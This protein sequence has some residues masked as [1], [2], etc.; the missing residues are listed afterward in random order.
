MSDLLWVIELAGAMLVWVRTR[1]SSRRQQQAGWLMAAG[2]VL[3]AL[4]DALEV[5]R[6]RS[7]F[8][9]LFESWQAFDSSALSLAGLLSLLLG[10]ARLT[11][12]PGRT[13]NSDAKFHSLANVAADAIIT[14]DEHGTI[15][16]FNLCAERMFGRSAESMIGQ[17]LHPIIPERYRRLHDDGVSRVSRS[18]ETPFDG[19][20]REFHALRKD[21]SEFPIELTVASWFGEDRRLSFIG[22]I[23]DITERKRLEAELRQLATTDPL[24][25][26][27]NRRRFTELTTQE[28]HRAHR[29]RHPLTLIMLDIDWFKRIND[30]FGHTV[31]DCV[32]Q[33]LAS[34]CASE[35]R[36]I[37][38]LGRLGGEEFAVVLP[39][40][41]AS[42]SLEVAERLRQKVEGLQITLNDGRIVRFTCSLGVAVLKDT[43]QSPDT[44]LVRADNALYR[45]KRDGRN[46]V[47]AAS[48]S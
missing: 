5:M 6:G 21:G 17:K 2:L 23:R 40:L 44:L 41:G 19:E 10:I 25:G 43:D 24:T 32:I 7:F 8:A 45:A 29:L 30:A 4:P 37:D 36:E 15:Q 26:I 46:C 18:G 33:S 11:T 14:I 9:A 34:A 1:G 39:E 28:I 13:D 35:L 20:T 16:S 31:G 3:G 42:G 27:L 48:D 12:A 22:I 38:I 47:R